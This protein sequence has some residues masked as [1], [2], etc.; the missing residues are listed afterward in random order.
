[1]NAVTLVCFAVPQEAKPFRAIAE[2]RADI[3]VVVTGM[4]RGN[5][6]RAAREALKQFEPRRVV[7]SG[8]AGALDPEL[9]VGDLIFDQSKDTSIDIGVLKRP[10][11]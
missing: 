3:R 5:A 1:M 2:Q 11:Q 6:Q 9:R 10:C 8:F 7:T 4:G